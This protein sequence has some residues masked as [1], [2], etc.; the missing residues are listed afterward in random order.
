MSKKVALLVGVGE[1][2]S[3]LPTLSASPNDVAGMQRILRDP[4]LGGFDQVDTMINP[5]LVAMQRAIKKVFTNCNKDDLVFFFFS[6]HGITDEDGAL[7]LAT[8][9]TAKDDFEA[10]A[11]HAR[12]IQDAMNKCYAKRQLVILDC[13]Y[14]GAFA[15]G[16]RAKSVGVDLK[17]LLGSE[18]RAVLTSSTALYTR[19][20]IEG[21]ETGA[22]DKDGNGRVSIQE[23]HDYAKT[24]VQEVKPKMKPE[25]LLDREGFNIILSR[26]IINNP[27]LAYRREVERCA[28]RG[29]ISTVD[30]ARLEFLQDKLGVP[31]E[32]ATQVQ[33]EILAP[34]QEYIKNLERYQGTLITLFTE[35][36]PPTQ[37]TQKELETLQDILGLRNEDIAPVNKKVVAQFEA[38]I[39]LQRHKEIEELEIASERNIDYRTLKKL[40]QEGRW[41]EADHETYE[42]MVLAAGQTS[43]DIV[44]DENIIQFP[45]TDLRTIDQLW[46]KYSNGRFGFSVQKQIWVGVG[47]KPGKR[48]DDIWDIFCER[49]GW[50]QDGKWIP[51]SEVCF[52][53]TKSLKGHL[54]SG[55]VFYFQEYW[56][57]GC[58][59]VFNLLSRPYLYVH[60]GEIQV[61]NNY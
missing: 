27:L 18:G 30:Y 44:R 13:C 60:S 20:L 32:Q 61:N 52:D 28:S 11:V 43:G 59:G 36:Y 34:F 46:V 51:Y 48:N 58:G 47:G 54:P 2:E 56:L 16:W 24:K 50:R 1:Y 3:D 29:K 6:G 25:I 38:K 19:Y 42:M 22:A 53:I 12:F 40:L 4:Q 37:D 5:G 7:Y 23:L 39:E 31:S 15:Q 8:R 33:H 10:T 9:I 41:E 26:T 57:W 21:I 17:Q 45:L 55:W 35:E 49:I 14:S